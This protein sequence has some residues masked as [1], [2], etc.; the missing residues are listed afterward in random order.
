MKQTIKLKESELRQLVT[1]TFKKVLKEQNRL[2]EYENTFSGIKN[3]ISGEVNKLIKGGG[4]GRNDYEDGSYK[5]A[6]KD[7]NNKPI[8]QEYNY[9][10]DGGF[11]IFNFN[12]VSREDHKKNLIDGNGK[13]VLP[14][15]VDRINDTKNGFSVIELNGKYNLMNMFGQLKFK[16]FVSIEQIPDKFH[17]SGR[18][19]QGGQS[20]PTGYGK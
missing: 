14:F 10:S 6:L 16:D 2:N 11:N 12:E 5:Y 3:T 20:N 17:I 8:S 9:M 19:M 4:V 7:R 15:W 13:L 1:E 18:N